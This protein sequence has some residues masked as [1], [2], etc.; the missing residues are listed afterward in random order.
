MSTFNKVYAFVE[1][2]AKGAHKFDGTHTLKVMLSNTAPSATDTVK[3]DIA[4]IATG[5]GYSAGG[6]SLTIISASQTL[7]VFKLVVDS[8][9][10]SAAGGSIGPFRYAVF[11]N[12]TQTT[13]A[14]PLIG[15]ADYSGSVTLQDGE[16]VQIS[17]DAISGLITLM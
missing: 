9:N 12:D 11:Y 6:P 10:I 13:P 15:W 16:S 14:K 17:T 1:D 8:V 7:G 3:A 2:V 5:N 4:E